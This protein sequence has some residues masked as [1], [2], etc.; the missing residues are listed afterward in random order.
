MRQID[1]MGG[2]DNYI[3][4]TSDDELVSNF[5]IEL[6]RRME[7]VQRMLDHGDKTLEEIKKD[8]APHINDKHVAPHV[9]QNGRFYFDWYGRT[10]H[11]IHC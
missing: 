9:E 6:K 10:R 8:I 1:Y 3:M 11:Q 2:F 4:R 5:A 7:T